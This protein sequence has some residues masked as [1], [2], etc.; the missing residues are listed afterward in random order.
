M[1]VHAI[2]RSRLVA[3]LRDLGLREGSAVMVHTRMSALGWAGPSRSR[4]AGYERAPCV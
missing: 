3:E 2:V 4:T 1:P